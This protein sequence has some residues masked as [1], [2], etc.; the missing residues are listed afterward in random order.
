MVLGT[1]TSDTDDV[2]QINI[3][4]YIVDAIIFGLTIFFGIKG[5]E[6]TGKNLLE[7]GWKF[8][9]EE[10]QTTHFARTKWSLG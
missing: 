1:F 9:A 5:N 10:D 2:S 4:Y 6:L 7:N 3:L 8:A